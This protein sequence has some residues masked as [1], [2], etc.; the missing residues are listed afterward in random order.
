MNSLRISALAGFVALTALASAPAFAQSNASQIPDLRGTQFDYPSVTAYDWGVI[1]SP[2]DGPQIQYSWAEV[3]RRL[4]RA[5]AVT[6]P[7]SARSAGES[8]TPQL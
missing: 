4:N 2:A 7:A 5:S 1:D 8:S 3:N 6:A